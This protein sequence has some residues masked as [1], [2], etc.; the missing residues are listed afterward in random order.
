MCG[1]CLFSVDHT[2]PALDVWEPGRRL[3]STVWKPHF[4]DREGNTFLVLFSSSVYSHGFIFFSVLFQ[5]AGHMVPQWAPGPAFH[6]FQ[7]FLNNV[8]YWA[9][10][11]HTCTHHFNLLS[12]TMRLIKKWES[13]KGKWTHICRVIHMNRLGCS[14]KY[15]PVLSV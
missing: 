8:S 1:K 6:F 15:K 9:S 7:S 14:Y 11:L 12:G 3:L 5:G 10:V 2:L 13:N 4:P